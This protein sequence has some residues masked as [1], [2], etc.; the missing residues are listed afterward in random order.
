MRRVPKNRRYCS[1]C[2]DGFEEPR[3][4]NSFTI[5]CGGTA[6]RLCYDCYLEYRRLFGYSPTGSGGNIELWLR[7]R[8]T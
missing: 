3:E 8:R 2:G 6:Y 4:L 7:S 5:S 1:R